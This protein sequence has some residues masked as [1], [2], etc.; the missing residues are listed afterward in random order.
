MS[1][2]DRVTADDVSRLNRDAIDRAA[3]LVRLA[4][5]ALVVVGLVGVAL[6]LWA[7]CRQQG[8]V[9]DTPGQFRVQSDPDLALRLDLATSTFS[10]LVSAALSLGLGC[11]LRLMADYAVARTDGSLAGV[12]VGDVIPPEGGWT[13]GMPPGT[14]PPPPGFRPGGGGGS[15]PP[16]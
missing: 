14:L 11:A 13:P 3:S 9:G 7:F 5:G 1:V 15:W 10:L 12:E 4:G 2:Q 16:G 8:L 6:W